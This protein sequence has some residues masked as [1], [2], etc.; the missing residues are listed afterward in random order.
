MQTELYH[1]TERDSIINYR[2]ILNSSIQSLILYNNNA[3]HIL[4]STISIRADLISDQNQIIN[5]TNIL[6]ENEQIINEIYFSTVALNQLDNLFNYAASLLNIALQCPLSGGPAVY[7]ARSLYY[8]I[9]PTMDYD[10]EQIC[11]QG[12]YLFKTS[13]NLTKNSKL[14]PNP[15]NSIVSIVY[16]VESNSVL[17][18]FDCYGR[19]INNYS[20]DPKNFIFSFETENFENGLYNYRIV[21]KKGIIIDTG[22]FIIMK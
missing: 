19:I 11:L 15:S 20:I 16:N 7:R 22:Q 3:F 18:I 5:G 6:E 10:D 21:D 1:E 13:R 4:D 8:I 14:Y 17:Q 2:N 9:D 12:G